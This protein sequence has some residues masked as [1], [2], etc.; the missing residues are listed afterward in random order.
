MGV[1]P[2]TEAR[3]GGRFAS[4]RPLFPASTIPGGLSPRHQPFLGAVLPCPGRPPGSQKSNTPLSGGHPSTRCGHGGPHL[5]RV[6]PPPPSLGLGTIRGSRFVLGQFWRF[7][8]VVI[9]RG[10]NQACRLRVP[11][12]G[13]LG[14]EGGGGATGAAFSLFE[15]SVHRGGCYL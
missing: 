5:A 10:S 8:G 11:P 2:Y 6:K 1:P 7:C 14:S 9:R 3:I 12:P 4:Q 13:G 15:Y